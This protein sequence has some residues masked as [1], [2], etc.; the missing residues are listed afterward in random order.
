[1]LQVKSPDQISSWMEDGVLSRF[2]IVRHL[3]YLSWTNSLFVVVD[4]F[5]TPLLLT[6]SAFVVLDQFGSV[7]VTFLCHLFRI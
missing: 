7:F 4:Q 1:M 5:G 3:C 2:V 6:N